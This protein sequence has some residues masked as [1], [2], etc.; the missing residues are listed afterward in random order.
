MTGGFVGNF[1]TTGLD[2]QGTL[3]FLDTRGW[4]VE[5]IGCPTHPCRPCISARASMDAAWIWNARRAWTRILMTAASGDDIYVLEYVVSCSC[6]SLWGRMICGKR[7]H[8]TRATL[9]AACDGEMMRPI[10]A[11]YAPGVSL[12]SDKRGRA[13]FHSAAEALPT[14]PA[15]FSGHAESLTDAS[16]MRDRWGLSHAPQSNKRTRRCRATR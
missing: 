13:H 2:T 3:M 1:W 6:L 14:M 7:S 12:P 4:A 11:M 16:G 5:N 9:V 15:A 8:P 10:R